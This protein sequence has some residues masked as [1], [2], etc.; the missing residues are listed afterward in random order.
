MNRVNWPIM[1]VGVAVTLLIVALLASGF[2]KD[3]KAL[4]DQLTGRDAPTFQLADLQGNVWT[5]DELEG[6][7][8]FINFWSTWCGP[9]KMEHPMLLQ[10][11]REYTD[12]QFLGIIYSDENAAVEMQMRRPPYTQ[13]MASL[14]E[15]GV[16]YP[17]LDDSSGRVALDYGVGGV[18]ESFFID[19]TGRITHKEV[20]PLTPQKLRA[21]LDRIRAQ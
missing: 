15:R 21:E 14:G 3:P 6:K 8:V 9:C 19:R 1:G 5:L 2:G 16:R 18:P 4:P 13:L 11:A 20:G 17:N 12:V 7:P 10:A